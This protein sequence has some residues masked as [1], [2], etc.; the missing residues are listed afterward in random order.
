LFNPQPGTIYFTLDGTDPRLPGGDVAG[1]ALTYD[2]SGPGLSLEATTHIKARLLDTSGEWSALVE[3]SYHI[4]KKPE[5]GDLVVSELHYRP[6]APSPAEVEAGFT[7]RG[8]FEFVEL[9]NRSDSTLNL[10]DVLFTD[11]IRF[12]FADADAALIAPGE[13]ILLVANPEAFASRHG[14]DLAIAGHYQDTQLSNGGETL[15]LTQRDG[16]V[17]LEF[18]YDDESPWPEEAD[19]AGR[20]LTLKDP[21]NT[22]DYN[23]PESWQASA[24]DGGSPG[25]PEGDAGGVDL[26]ADED[27]DGLPV[28]AE[29][30]LG[31]SDNDPHSGR[32]RLSVE[33]TPDGALIVTLRKSPDADRSQ[34]QLETSQDLEAWSPSQAAPESNDDDPARLQW[35][36]DANSNAS[37]L[38]IEI[39]P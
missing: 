20:S 28:F 13:R 10:E 35:N 6:T 30:A 22:T 37:H 1:G 18:T 7:T 31:T 33:R 19:G 26:A 4:G 14:S 25:R 15:L 38:R 36:L 11:G 32:D 39:K 23:S 2:R 9:Y 34:F 12:D 17:L 3:G 24:E 21:D 5:P 27:G 16:A 8:A 29:V